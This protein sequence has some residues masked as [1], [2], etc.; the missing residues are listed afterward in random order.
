MNNE[1]EKEAKKI[2]PWWRYAEDYFRPVH[3]TDIARIAPTTPWECDAALRSASLGPG[4]EVGKDKIGIPIPGLVYGRNAD[5]TRSFRA[6]VVFDATPTVKGVDPVV[7]TI[8]AVPDKPFVAPPL[9]E[10][11]EGIELIQR[12]SG[13]QIAAITR[14]ILSLDDDEAK[15]TRSAA[16]FI[17]VTASVLK[18]WLAKHENRS[19]KTSAKWGKGAVKVET[20]SDDAKDRTLANLR[21]WI[22]HEAAE[23]VNNIQDDLHKAANAAAIKSEDVQKLVLPDH[24]TPEMSMTFGLGLVSVPSNVSVQQLLPSTASKYEEL[25]DALPSSATTT[26]TIGE[27]QFGEETEEDEDTRERTGEHC[28]QAFGIEGELR[29]VG[30]LSTAEAIPMH[31]RLLLDRQFTLPDPSEENDKLQGLPST[32]SKKKLSGKDRNAS[33]ACEVCAKLKTL[34]YK[35]GKSGSSVNCLKRVVKEEILLPGMPSSNKHKKVPY[36]VSVARDELAKLESALAADPMLLACA[37]VDEVEG[38]ILAQQYELLWNLQANKLNVKN[39]IEKVAKGLDQDTKT[40]MKR[41]TKIDEANA[42]MGAI[43]EVKRQQKKEKREAEQ[44]AALERANAAAPEGRRESKPKREIGSAAIVSETMTA[45]TGYKPLSTQTVMRA[46]EAAPARVKKMFGL[47]NFDGTA[48]HLKS[49]G[50][51]GTPRSNS[52]VLGGSPIRSPMS[53][54]LLDPF[55]SIGD[56][57]A[58]CVCAGTSEASKMKNTIKCAMCDLIVH[59]PCYGVSGRTDAKWTCWVCA[60]AVANDRAADSRQSGKSTQITL[61]GKLALYK[62]VSCALC[63]V[64]I[65]ALKQTLDGKQ[66]CHVACAKWVPEASIADKN[67]AKAV[68]PVSINDVPRER[69]NASCSYC[70]RSRG[71]LMRCCSGHCQIVFHPLCCRRA[72]CHMRGV[73]SQGRHFTAFCEKHSGAER[74]KDVESGLMGD[75]IPALVELYNEQPLERQ[76]SGGLPGIGAGTSM[77]GALQRV[78]ETMRA[79]KREGGELPTSSKATNKKSRGNFRHASGMLPGIPPSRSGSFTSM[80]ASGHVFPGAGARRPGGLRAGI[81]KRHALLTAPDVARVNNALPP[82]YR[83]VARSDVMPP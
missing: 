42:F 45:P 4:Y 14:T 11:E 37:P 79:N 13:T 40:F 8:P 33:D 48:S 56:N 46:I 52:P 43:R 76:L 61:Q 1:E 5:G 59:P 50:W 10:Y 58:C 34:G 71:T 17:G 65:G 81:L 3:A 29:H 57:T 12:L 54:I 2:A 15:K 7:G 36:K 39:L 74:E 70:T 16:R 20:D 82:G 62:G 18:A 55:H 23:R 32:S 27:E 53:Q 35:C 44:R 21:I 80:D 6:P 60:D 26:V 24:G 68:K 49:L 67:A 51:P 30:V 47:A 73:D 63:P 25:V 75:P 22:R 83:Y 77:H 28:R 69:R 38:E 19:A 72:A 78:R 41:K 9:E 64:Q 66:W 31:T